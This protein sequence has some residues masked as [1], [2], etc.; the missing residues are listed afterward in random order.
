T[1]IGAIRSRSSVWRPPSYGSARAPRA[2]QRTPGS[3]AAAST[4]D[5]A[6]TIFP[7]KTL[8]DP[9]ACGVTNRRGVKLC[10]QILTS[11][12]ARTDN[13]TEAAVLRGAREH[14]GLSSIPWGS[15]V[16]HHDEDL[17][18]PAFAASPTAPGLDL[19]VRPLDAIRHGRI[20]CTAA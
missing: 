17:S 13:C 15:S 14:P 10:H 19:L 4:A 3:V 18:D 7:T 1:A 11:N 5:Y 20:N 2:V 9:G 12:Q 16:R 8:S 6:C